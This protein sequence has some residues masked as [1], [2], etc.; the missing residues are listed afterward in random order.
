MRR[1]VPLNWSNVWAVNT[2]A[3]FHPATQW[4][5]A[6]DVKQ[7]RGAMELNLRESD[8]EV[9]LAYQT[10]NV[11]NN[12]DSATA[13][14]SYQSSNG[15]AYPTAW[16]DIGTYTEQKQ[17][18]RFGW[19]VKNTAGSTRTWSRVAGFVEISDS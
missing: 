17:I 11:E 7:V 2:S 13:L 3:I 9:S 15:V 10:A 4:I 6:S 1:K 18:I 19:L 12:A 14:G 5:P 16:E 8:Q